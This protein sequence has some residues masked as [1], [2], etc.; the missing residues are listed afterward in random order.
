MELAANAES[1]SNKE[2][3]NTLPNAFFFKINSFD[4]KDFAFVLLNFLSCFE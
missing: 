1:P 2:F 4:G 3:Q